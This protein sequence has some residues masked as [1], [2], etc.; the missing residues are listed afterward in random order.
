MYFTVATH[1]LQVINCKLVIPLGPCY[2][3]NAHALPGIH[4]YNPVEIHGYTCNTH[5]HPISIMCIRK[6][7]LSFPGTGV[8]RYLTHFFLL[9]SAMAISFSFST[10]LLTSFTTCCI[11]RSAAARTYMYIIWCH[12]MQSYI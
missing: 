3:S 8:W 11:S 5:V 4:L 12:R 9:V 2:I 6:E 7:M 10:C 1:V